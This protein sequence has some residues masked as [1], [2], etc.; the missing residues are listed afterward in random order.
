MPF[1]SAR[2]NT[3]QISLELFEFVGVSIE[4]YSKPMNAD[5][6]EITDISLK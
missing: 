4:V 5:K 3:I 6:C 1:L 2:S